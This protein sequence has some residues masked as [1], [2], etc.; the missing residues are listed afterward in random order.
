M[1]L[2]IKQLITLPAFLLLAA[3]AGDGAADDS[4]SLNRSDA[5]GGSAIF[6]SIDDVD[7]HIVFCKE[8][9]GHLTVWTSLSSE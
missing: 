6:F 3:C 5:A 1:D 8:H 4:I 7:L 2:R 9:F